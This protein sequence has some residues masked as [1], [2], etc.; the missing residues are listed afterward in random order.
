MNSSPD[1]AP[2]VELNPRPGYGALRVALLLHIL[3]LAA[4]PLLFGS[5]GWLLLLLA[6]AV[7]ASWLFVRRHSALGFGPRALV[8]I[9]AETDG[10]WRLEDAAQRRYSATLET[11]CLLSQLVVL[12]FRLDNGRRRQRLLLGDEVDKESLR[13]LRVRLLT[14]PNKPT[15][16]GKTD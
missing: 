2:T 9:V 10:G 7:G 5:G 11:G 13:R 1:S 6:G 15:A 12:S 8:R 4:M 16:L 14:R 3:P